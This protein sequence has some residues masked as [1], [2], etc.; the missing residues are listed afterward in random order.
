MTRSKTVQEIQA[1]YE[2]VKEDMTS[3]TAKQA[4]LQQ[5]LITLNLLQQF[6]QHG[7]TRPQPAWYVPGVGIGFNQ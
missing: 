2:G 1:E 3:L 5:Q 7:V 6:K 4:R